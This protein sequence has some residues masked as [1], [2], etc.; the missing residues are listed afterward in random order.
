MFVGYALDLDGDVY[1][2]WNPKIGWVHKTC[3]VIWLR[4]MYFEKPVEQE[5]IRIMPTL[6]E[7]K[8]VQARESEVAQMT[9]MLSESESVNDHSEARERS[10][11]NVHA[12]EARKNDDGAKE[13]KYDDE[14]EAIK[15]TQSGQRGGDQNDTIRLQAITKPTCLIEEYGASGYDNYSIGLTEAEQQYY[16]IMR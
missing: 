14:E 1:Q 12:E 15:M 11:M 9:E 2:M 8:M 3:N 6:D 13:E 16:K 10:G 4:R 7:N 5:E